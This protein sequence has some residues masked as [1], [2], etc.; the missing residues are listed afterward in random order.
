MAL[1][2]SKITFVGSG[3]IEA[4]VDTILFEDTYLTGTLALAEAGHADLDVR[5]VSNSI[6]GALNELLD[7][8]ITTSGQV[9]STVMCHIEAIDSPAFV[10]TITHN[11][12]TSGVLLQIYD[13]DP[14][15]VPGAATNVNACWFP[16][17]D[18]NI[19][20]E[21]DA[22]ASGYFVVVGC[23]PTP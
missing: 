13:Q 21:F 5:F 9:Q 18:N 20:V 1:Q 22:A 10:H 19:R 14:G 8:L 6:L 12:A 2:N 15:S 11:L 3:K 4:S 17:D 16:V 23:P 7:G